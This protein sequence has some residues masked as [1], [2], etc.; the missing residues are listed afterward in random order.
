M[1][2]N[3]KKLLHI[4][5]DDC[6][7]NDVGV[8]FLN[9]DYIIDEFAGNTAGLFEDAPKG[10]EQLTV[11]IK[12]KPKIM[13]W[14]DVM[15]HEYCHFLQW[16]NKTNIQKKYNKF[17][18]KHGD[19]V[20]KYCQGKR[21]TKKLIKEATRLTVLIEAEAETMTADMLKKHK[22]D[23]DI[24]TYM[25]MTE[26]TDIVPDKFLRYIDYEKYYK[27]N[28]KDIDSFMWKYGV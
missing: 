10:K 28:Q 25:K 27:D 13:S 18:T 15:V 22:I 24:P 16:K 9:D 12:R 17:F 23:I 19:P 4:I 5:V 2:K 20:L 7:E 6:I 8:N 3:I 14:V 11:S 21:V 1:D 26:K